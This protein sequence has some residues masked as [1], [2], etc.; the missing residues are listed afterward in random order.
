M[1]SEISCAIL[2][3]SAVSITPPY[4]AQ[5][6]QYHRRTIMTPL[7]LWASYARALA[8][9]KM[10]NYLSLKHT[11]ANC[12]SLQYI[13]DNFHAKSIGV[14]QGLFLVKALSFIFTLPWNYLY[15]YTELE[16]VNL[17]PI[18][19]LLFFQNRYSQ[20]YIA[21]GFWRCYVISKSR[22]FLLGGR[23][24]TIPYLRHSHLAQQHNYMISFRQRNI[25]KYTTHM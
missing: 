25:N 20:S 24:P 15:T 8:T 23:G 10:N 11:Y 12:L 9:F 21:V 18:A 13:Y 17:N 4:L 22:S 16:F 7:C 2:L 6:C 5:R 14:N 19:V 3:K 1:H